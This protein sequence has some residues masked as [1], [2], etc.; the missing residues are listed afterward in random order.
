MSVRI[1]IL[2]RSVLCE[3]RLRS[4][5]YLRGLSHDEVLLR[6]VKHRKRHLE[7]AEIAVFI[8]TRYEEL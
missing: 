2:P 6:E 7:A 1:E 3:M 8:I 5:T 4:R